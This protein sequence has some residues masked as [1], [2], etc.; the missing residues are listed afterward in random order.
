MIITPAHESCPQFRQIEESVNHQPLMV[1]KHDSGA[2]L[3][4]DSATSAE[5]AIHQSAL[6]ICCKNSHGHEEVFVHGDA[7]VWRTAAG[8]M[9]PAPSYDE[10][11][12]GLTGWAE[13]KALAAAATAA[14]SSAHPVSP[15]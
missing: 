11:Q 12:Y 8:N 3:A 7:T 14:L 2:L 9:K 1:Y 13:D 15:Y 6:T 4:P 5:V 10:F